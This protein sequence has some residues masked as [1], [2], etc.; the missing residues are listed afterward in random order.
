MK[1]L[2][3]MYL[4]VCPAL[5]DD[6]SCVTSQHAVYAYET[7]AECRAAGRQYAQEAAAALREQGIELMP[8]TECVP[9]DLG[10]EV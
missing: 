8:L 3:V 1:A 9:E 6:G 5:P 7:L 2:I 4:V 10:L